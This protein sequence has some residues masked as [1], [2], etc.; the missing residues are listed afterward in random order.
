VISQVTFWVEHGETTDPLTE[1][2]DKADLNIEG[3]YVR[4][5]DLIVD[6]PCP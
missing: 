1:F 5:F 2:I 4:D 3:A 6:V